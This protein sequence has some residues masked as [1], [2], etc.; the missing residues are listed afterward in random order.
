MVEPR[1]DGRRVRG[2]A[3][4]ARVL[5]R[6]GDLAS[7]E[8]LEGLTL[9]RLGSD[10]GISRS[11][12]H[13]LFGSS[14]LE[15]QLA[16]VAAARERFVDAVVIPALPRSPGMDRLEALLSAWLRY[17]DT[18]VFPGGCFVLHGLNEYGS[19]ESRVR[20]ALVACRQEWLD[21]LRGNLALA[22][23][24]GDL[25]CP[26]RRQL[27]FE[28]DALLVGANTARLAG[29]ERAVRRARVAI[30]AMLHPRDA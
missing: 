1:P 12:V 15:L 9:S 21:L 26:D 13:A 29:D 25:S 27:L 19:R 28:M 4:R 18:G 8:G 5:R 20:D 6:A 2:D 10:L 24:G 22:V 23:R 16:T 3:S 7:T 11:N 14:K 17:I 30:A